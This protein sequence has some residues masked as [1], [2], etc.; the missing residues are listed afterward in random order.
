MIIGYYLVVDS[1]SYILPEKHFLNGIVEVAPTTVGQYT[2]LKDS[3][4]KKIFEG[5]ILKWDER[6]WGKV[7]F[8]VVTWDYDLFAMR[9]KDWSE[10]CVVCGNIHDTPELLEKK[11][12]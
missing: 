6:E 5:D 7:H 10:F 8:E 1:I 4:G 2:G 11:E 3:S 9:A 12:A